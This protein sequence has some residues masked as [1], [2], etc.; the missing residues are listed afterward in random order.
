MSVYRYLQ[1]TPRGNEAT[2]GNE[3]VAR[4]NGRSWWHQEGDEFSAFG[5][6]DDLTCFDLVEVAAGVLAKL[7]Y[8]DSR[9]RKIVA[10]LVLLNVLFLPLSRMFG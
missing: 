10:Q 7:S 8:S 5:D 4:G 1:C 6:F 9:H 3:S 2:R